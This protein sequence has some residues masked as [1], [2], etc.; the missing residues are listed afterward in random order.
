MTT[1]SVRPEA[2]PGS[3]AQRTGMATSDH[4][5]PSEAHIATS[6]NGRRQTP[7][8]GG[9]AARCTGWPPTHPPPQA[10]PHACT[11]TPCR[12]T[13]ST[14]GGTVGRGTPG[15]S[16]CRC[17]GSSAK[18]E[19]RRSTRHT[20]RHT[21]H[22]YTLT[23]NATCTTVAGP[24]QRTALLGCRGAVDEGHLRAARPWVLGTS[25][26]D[27]LR[28]APGVT[29]AVRTHAHAVGLG[30]CVNLRHI[31]GHTHPHAW[32]PD[33]M[34]ESLWMGMVGGVGEGEGGVGPPTHHDSQPP[35]PPNC[36]ERAG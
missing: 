8:V 22:T 3:R 12:R 36:P 30:G 32:A 16:R 21:T 17:Q 25:G 13:T 9:V 2:T 19:A 34:W 7:R 35:G 23:Q 27:G 24:H 18:T 6:P 10:T 28:A 4:R 1:C 15:S 14:G 20:Q 29:R 26:H 11:R 31:P 33:A 5:S